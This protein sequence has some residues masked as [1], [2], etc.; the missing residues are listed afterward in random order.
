[1]F[2]VE[3]KSK[4]IKEYVYQELGKSYNEPLLSVDLDKIKVIELDSLDFLGEKTDVSIYDLVFFRN[5]ESCYLINMEFNENEFEVLNMNKSIKDLHLINCKFNTKKELKLNLR[6]L[7]FDECDN[8]N[9]SICNGIDSLERLRIINCANVNIS[10]IS[11]LNNITDLF[12]QNLDI[13]NI[14]EIKN[15]KKLK[16]LNL[17]GCSYILNYDKLKSNEKITI[18]HENEINGVQEEF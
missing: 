1:M 6:S 17:N 12:L 11:R 14:D 10:G 2:E 9:V 4:T 18:V 3:L 13:Q 15:M 16:N 8:V 7:I 5:L